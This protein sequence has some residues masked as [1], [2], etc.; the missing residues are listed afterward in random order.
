MSDEPQRIRVPGSAGVELS[1]IPRLDAGSSATP[2][3]MLVHGLASNARLWDGVGEAL[4][5]R[6]YPSVALDLRGHGRSDK[7]DDGYD[8]GTVTT[9][10]VAVI[11]ALGLDRPIVA[12][13]SWG[14]NVVLELGAR[15]PDLVRGVIGVDGGTIELSAVFPDWDTCAAVLAP[16]RL[17]GTPVEKLEAWVRGAHPDWPESGIQGTLANFEVREDGT[18]APWLTRERHMRIL[19]S[20]WEHQP[21]ERYAAVSVP[22]LLMPAEGPQDEPDRIADR[23][24]SIDLA[25]SLLTKARVRWFRP[26]DHDLHAQHPGEAANVIVQAVEEGFFA[27]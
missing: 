20:L 3:V 12:G 10:L 6:G 9:D 27:P 1:A 18:I 23:R 16:P 7:P 17:I 24:R 21:S 11:E 15:H 2:P 22:M 26:A 13:Q 19:C 8:F 5:G 25:E 14:G 4:A